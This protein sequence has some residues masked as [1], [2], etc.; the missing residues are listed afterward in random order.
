MTCLTV[1]DKG[2]TS[3][4]YKE[5]KNSIVNKQT[6]SPPKRYPS[7]SISMVKKLSKDLNR[8]FSNEGI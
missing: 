1:S 4:I 5:L 8:H 3:K 2:F 7:N 6:K